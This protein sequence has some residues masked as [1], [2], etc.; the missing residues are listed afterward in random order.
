MF[1]FVLPLLDLEEQEALPAGALLVPLLAQLPDRARAAVCGKDSVLP[2]VRSRSGGTGRAQVVD[3]G[4]A[5]NCA[6]SSH[7]ATAGLRTPLERVAETS[8]V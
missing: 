7:C 8:Q 3:V 2:R 1:V 6:A 4:R 5:G